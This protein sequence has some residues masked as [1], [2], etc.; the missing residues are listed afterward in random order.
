M[1]AAG[2]TGW[3]QDSP[4]FFLE[5]ARM[6]ERFTKKLWGMVCRGEQ[7]DAYAIEHLLVDEARCCSIHRH[8]YRHNQFIV[9]SG[10]LA[11]LTWPHY[12][13][14]D[15]KAETFSAAEAYESFTCKV[16]EASR[17]RP[18]SVFVAAGIPHQFISLSPAVAT[19]IYTPAGNGLLSSDDIE[20]FTDGGEIPAGLMDKIAR[21]WA[22]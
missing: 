7:C 9:V 14:M 6:T 16:L 8:N 12:V 17:G 4:P 13:G 10:A 1:T 21:G 3:L 11:V 18:Q 15:L 20:R 5:R 19:E 2:W 22:S